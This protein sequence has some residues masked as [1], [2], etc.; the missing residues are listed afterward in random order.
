MSRHTASLG[1]RCPSEPEQP[2][3]QGAVSTQTATPC[4]IACSL[5]THQAK[6]CAH[7]TGDVLP[8]A[9]DAWHHARPA[10]EVHGHAVQQPRV[11]RPAGQAGMQL[12]Q[13]VLAVLRPL[14]PLNFARLRLHSSRTGAQADGC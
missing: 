4:P 12:V 6:S 7:L 13:V 8:E 2:Y 10:H 11:P 14:A 9:L 5:R 3:D 1:M